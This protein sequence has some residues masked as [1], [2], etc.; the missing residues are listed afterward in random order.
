MLIMLTK[1]NAQ[2]KALLDDIGAP[3]SSAAVKQANKQAS[4]KES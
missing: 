4:K 2:L 1:E 3:L